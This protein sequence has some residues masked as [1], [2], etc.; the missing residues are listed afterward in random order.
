MVSY[1]ILDQY[2]KDGVP[3]QSVIL[4]CTKKIGNDE[5]EGGHFKDNL[6][7][8]GGEIGIM[9]IKLVGHRICCFGRYG[10]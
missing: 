10:A 3:G 2:Q 5:N 8:E 7:L 6:Q 4:L 1:Y 9:Y